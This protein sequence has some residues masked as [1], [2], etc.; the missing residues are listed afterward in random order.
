MPTVPTAAPNEMSTEQWALVQNL[1]RQVA[2]LRGEVEELKADKQRSDRHVSELES[3]IRDARTKGT[4]DSAGPLELEH[5]HG[6][7]HGHGHG[8]TAQNGHADCAVG[9]CPHE[10]EPKMKVT[11]LS[12]FLGAGKTTLLKRILTDN[13]QK[14]EGENLKIAVVVNDMGEINL[15]ADDIKHSK[16][17]QEDAEM[18]E[19]H[20]G[21][22]CCT[23]RGDLLKTVKSLSDEG[24]Y[25]C[26]VIESTGIS[27]PLPVA[28]TF[29]MDVDDHLNTLKPSVLH[30]LRSR[31][32]LVNE[33]QESL[34]DATAAGDL[35]RMA[36]LLDAGH[37]THWRTS[38]I[39][40]G[41]ADDENENQE[42]EGKSLDWTPLHV[43]AQIRNIEAV[44]LLLERGADPNLT[45]YTNKSLT[46]LMVAV[47]SNAADI[48][49]LLIK[50]GADVDV[51]GHPRS[52]W[53]LYGYAR[54]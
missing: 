9:C 25:D 23:L 37:A 11:V 5:E 6:H 42:A 49:K 17:V 32:K 41:T 13:N 3:L 31:G 36:E 7:G 24:K 16:L 18:V 39:E 51:A 26:L 28:Q 8:N 22:I 46:V 30:D 29:V 38:V 54:R 52:S 15:D 45:A 10:T 53:M 20:N 33:A 47:M 34:A 14:K 1:V 21:C 40:V 27:E 12:G 2:E 43:A 35:S 50:H 44:R 48:V 4:S 19:L